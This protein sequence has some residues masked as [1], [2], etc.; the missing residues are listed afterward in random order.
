VRGS[1]RNLNREGNFCKNIS[2]R[3]Q[4]ETSSKTT[5]VVNGVISLKSQVMTSNYIT[6][7]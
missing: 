4:E 3:G 1:Q 5:A 7:Q 2:V 6:K